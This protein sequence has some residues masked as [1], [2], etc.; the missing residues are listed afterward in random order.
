MLFRSRYSSRIR[1]N[2]WPRHIQEHQ[3]RCELECLS[4]LLKVLDSSSTRH[5][6]RNQSPQLLGPSVIIQ[7]TVSQ[8]SEELAELILSEDDRS[9]HSK[10]AFIR[11][12]G[13]Q[14]NA[15][16]AIGMLRGE[17]FAEI[18]EMSWLA[19]ISKRSLAPFLP[20]HGCFFPRQS[21]HKRCRYQKIYSLRMLLRLPAGQSPLA[22]LD[23][24]S[25]GPLPSEDRR[26]S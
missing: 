4:A 6:S 10:T 5:M 2:L 26:A 15:C 18:L 13:F 1:R 11:R 20:P 17:F 7:E 22:P 25:H 21:W 3:W 8:K 16:S 9:L 19:K 14:N 24:G 23:H 12:R